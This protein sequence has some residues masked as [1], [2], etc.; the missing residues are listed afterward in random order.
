[1]GSYKYKIVSFFILQVGI[2]LGSHCYP[3]LAQNI[4]HN[5]PSALLPISPDSSSIQPGNNSNDMAPEFTQYILAPGDSINVSVQR[6]PGL[7]RLGIGDGIAVNVERF[8]DL[9]FQGV[10]NPEGNVI[11]PLLGAVFLQGLT[12][13]E[14]Q[15]KIRSLLDR[16]VINPNVVLALVVQRPNLSFQAAI[17]IDGNILVPQVGKIFL[18]GLTV[19]AAQAKIKLA[20]SKIAPD[21]MVDVSL[22]GMR[23]VQL[24]IT[25]EVFKPGIYSVTTV[26]PKITD[27]ILLAGGSTIKANLR[28]VLVR[29][30]LSNGL[31]ISQKVDLYAVLQNGSSPPNL[32]LQDGDA[33]IIPQ[34]QVAT[35]N[36]YDPS[37]IARSTLAVPQ[38]KVRVLNYAAGGVIMQNLP[39]GS[40]FVDALGGVSLDKNNLRDIV[41]IRFDPQKGKAITKRL[42][43]K[44]ALQGDI[45]QNVALQD[46]DVIVVGRNLVGKVTNLLNT[47]T[48]PFFNVQSFVR[49]FQNFGTG[50]FGGTSN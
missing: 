11:V 20:L 49:F 28:E 30:Q 38:I 21:D 7:Y 22:S 36:D 44:K 24:T 17:G 3:V 29:R 34:R 47:I 4:S 32:R 8:P 41:L 39:N 25:G 31:I 27:I 33:I 6:P 15:S 1:M 45:S 2:S 50:L 12:L 14:A 18:Q 13:Q 43:A 5:S 10:I 16:Y 46:N 48:Q 9:S 37:L 26:M 19:E 35:D 40:S 42:D 23:P